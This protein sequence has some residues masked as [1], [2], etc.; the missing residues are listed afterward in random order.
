MKKKLYFN[1]LL[2]F[3]ILTLWVSIVSASE[4]TSPSF[5]VRDPVIGAGGGYASSGS[6]NLF[7]SIDSLLIGVG[8]SATFFIGHYGFLY[9]EDEAVVIPPPPPPGGGGGGARVGLQL[10]CQI[11]DFNC[12]NLV[13]IFDLSILLYY[14]DQPSPVV[15]LYDLSKDNKVDFVDTSIVFYYWDI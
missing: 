6:F 13:N 7:Q 11:A 8:S 4:L 15:D 3:L 9:F 14:M 10:N 12:D 2:C 1:F 5:I